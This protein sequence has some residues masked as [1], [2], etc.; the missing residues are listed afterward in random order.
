MKQILIR[1]T[2]WE[3]WPFSLFYF[4]V[5]FYY[6]WLSFRKRSLFFFT[7]ANPK[8]EFGGMFGER[9]SD[10]FKLIP[11]EFIPETYLIARGDLK[12]AKAKS[13]K[14]GF[15]LIA[16]P[17]IGERGVWVKKIKS[18][19]ELAAYA[20]A[21]PVE[22]LLQKFIEYPIEL[23]V[24][25]VR[26][27]HKEKGAVTSIVRKN[28]LKVT[29]DGMRSINEL[30][31]ENTR[32]L[33]TA[34]LESEYL[35]KAGG[36]IPK[37]GEEVLIEPIGNHCRGTRF[38]NDNEQIDEDLNEAIDTLAKQIS[39]FY[40]GRFD[41]RCKSYKELKQLRAF[42]ILELNGAGSEPGHIY[43]P[44]YSLFRAYR[45][46]LWHLNILADIS[47]QN[48]LSGVPYCTLKKGVKKWRAHQIYNRLLNT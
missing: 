35:K 40:F 29:G 28:F 5:F 37:R 48:K 11:K 7:S 30:L 47:E 2:Q 14:I 12:D 24:F 9:K 38:L 33:L 6:F 43:Q 46:I 16:K 42:K 15:P 17:D 10:I 13:E 26:Y 22:F 25:Y 36:S 1:L 31:R 41:L 19:E 34:D 23:G 39:G 32:A 4:P 20:E 8:I 44:G 27:P 45:D 21:C 18:D 3:Y